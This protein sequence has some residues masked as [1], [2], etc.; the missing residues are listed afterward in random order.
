M[1]MIIILFIK[2]ITNNSD[3][4]LFAHSYMVSSNK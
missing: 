4:N 3:D 2:L 1:Q